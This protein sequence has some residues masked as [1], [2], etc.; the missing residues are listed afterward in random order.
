LLAR[1]CTEAGQIEKSAGFWGKAVQRSLERSA[2]VEA[3]E[4]LTRALD[5]IASLSA[6][7]ALRREEIKLQVGLI[8]PLIHVKGYAAPETT[9]AAERARL[10]IEQA[11]AL[12][13]PPEEPLLLFSVLY[14]LWVANIVA[15]NGDVARNHATQFLEFAEKQRATAPL[16][17]GH[18]MMGISLTMTGDI[19]KAQAHCD[20]A[21]ALYDPADHRH[22]ATRFGVDARVAVLSYRSLSLWIIG[23]PDAALADAERALKDAREIGQAA[24][25]MYALFHAAYFAYFH[26][27]NYAATNVLLHELIALADDKGAAF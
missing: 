3:A 13:E 2:L 15:F 17:M 12:G 14:G 26:R 1:H 16:M 10:L 4:Q 25:L 8:T 6:T 9:A 18:R 27:R 5:Q 24:T 19:A 11:Q 23:R 22:L 20:L 7:P 21:F